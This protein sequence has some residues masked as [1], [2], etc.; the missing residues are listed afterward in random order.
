[1]YRELDY[2]V[3]RIIL[4]CADP[5]FPSENLLKAVFVE[6]MLYIK[7]RK[8]GYMLV[9]PAPVTNQVNDLGLVMPAGLIAIRQNKPSEPELICG[10]DQR[11]NARPT[12]RAAP[13]NA[14]AIPIVS[15]NDSS[16]SYQRGAASVK[17]E[18][19]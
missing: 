17:I 15:M 7:R 12:A 3:F 9:C 11:S 8:H 1:M 18:N 16:C 2:L 13:I 5:R 14:N 10:L 19:Y 6:E 4:L